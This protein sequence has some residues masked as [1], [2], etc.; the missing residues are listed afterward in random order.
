MSN[1]SKNESLRIL[2][3]ST[4]VY[5]EIMGGGSL[6]AH[7]MSRLQSEMGH[8][9]TLLTSDHGD[10]S[11]PRIEERAGYTIHR[12]RQV[13]R[14]IENS[15]MPGI[16]PQIWQLA[17][18]HDVIHAHSH[19][20]FS[21][22][23][24]ALLARVVDTPFVLTNH[25]LRSQTAPNLVMNTFL[26]TI[27]RLTFESADQILCYTE[28]DLKRLRRL[29]IEAP[30][31]II[32]NGVDC[33][34]FTPQA[35][36]SQEK[37]I[38]FVGRLKE[39]KGVYSLIRAFARV[40]DEHPQATLTIVG[41]GPLKDSLVDLVEKHHLSDKVEFRGN[42]PNHELPSIYAESTVFSLPTNAEGLPRTVLEALACET[43]VLT[44]DLPQLEPLVE[45]VGLTFSRG[46]LD[47]LECGLRKMLDDAERR[48]M[49]G[50]RG[51]KRVM[52]NYSWAE[53]V[54]E[55]TDV[56]YK[57]LEKSETMDD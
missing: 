32:H 15:I 42:I 35:G 23:I 4:D 50:K 30:I 40:T 22:N 1:R 51:R 20:Y 14:P 19:L 52:K 21:S 39:S 48:E 17:D 10:R 49:M 37:Q 43:P 7:E 47:K 44:S 8:Q 54:R 5:P 2:R 28:T 12:S 55:T 53:T 3:I 16:I 45:G 24:A 57:I 9:V 38:L 41:E 26:R 36:E 27:G 31:S 56:Y 18:D 13:A 6:H 46:S 25:G 11:A 34:K 29:N 33:E